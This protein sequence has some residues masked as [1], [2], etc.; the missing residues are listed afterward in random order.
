MTEP[1]DPT[2]P[3]AG[4]RVVEVSM[5]GPGAIST[6]LADLGADVIKV[7]PPGGDYGRQMT[8]PIVEG[9]SLLF[10]HVSRGK[11]SVELDLRTDEG[12]A[13]FR[14]LA[15]TA[16]VVI[17]AMRPGG[18]ARR[19]LGPEVLRERNPKLVFCTISGYGATGPYRNLPSHGVAYDAWAG[20]IEPVRDEH[21]RPSIPMHTSIGINAG[22]L[23]GALA[24]LA[25]VIGARATGQGSDLEVA[26]SD[27]ALAFDWL[28]SETIRAYERPA[29]EVTGNASDNYERRPPGIA[30]MLGSVRYQI[31]D[32][33]DLPVLF[34]ASEQEFWKNFCEGV[35]RADMFAKYPGA[36]FADHARGNTEIADFLTDTF[37]TRTAAEWTQFGLDHNVPIVTVNTPASL[38]ADPQVQARMPWLSQ[39]VLGADQLPF[40]VRF[41]GQLP[42]ARGKAPACGEHTTEILNHETKTGDN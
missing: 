21:G 9:T 10:L 27:A 17:E 7:E 32:A 33:A 40:P 41:D 31:Y 30:G 38:S 16:D 25:A 37:R 36:K 13:A 4:V 39:D 12:A 19:G 34:Q 42:P 28:R 24:V 15:A 35:G 1:H 14:D 2:A 3:L 11:R 29:D 23:Y 18:L 26:Q 8:W 5:L 22:P 6:P 20:V